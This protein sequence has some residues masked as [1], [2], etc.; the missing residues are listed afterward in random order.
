MI[1]KSNLVAR[2]CSLL[3]ILT[4]LRRAKVKVVYLEF[5][6]KSNPRLTIDLIMSGYRFRLNTMR[7]GIIVKVRNLIAVSDRKLIF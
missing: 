1:N 2:D 5:E 6:G 7:I 3:F 4:I